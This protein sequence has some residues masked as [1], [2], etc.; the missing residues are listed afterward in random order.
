MIYSLFFDGAVKNKIASFG[1]VLYKNQK[2][3]D[4]G[5]GI[6]GH[7]LSSVD[8]EKQALAYGLDS[9]VRKVDTRASLNIYGDSKFVISTVENDPALR[10]RITGVRKLGIPVSYK[11]VPRSE[12]KLANDLAKK[13]RSVSDC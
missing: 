7:G 8:A 6:I 1:F 5:Y 10:S 4:R 3:C 9:F 2:E 13:L 12:N 11:W